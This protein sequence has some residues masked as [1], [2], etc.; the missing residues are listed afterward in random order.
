[1]L[2]RALGDERARMRRIQGLPVHA[3]GKWPYAK[4][5]FV[6]RACPEEQWFVIVVVDLQA[7]V[8]RLSLPVLFTLA[9]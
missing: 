9:R 1:V 3:R 5:F 4:N 7:R 2:P 6:L 8:L